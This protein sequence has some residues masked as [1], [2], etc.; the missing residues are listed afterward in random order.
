MPKDEIKFED[1]LQNVPPGNLSFVHDMHDFMLQN[2]CTYKIAEA[3]SGH[4]L[5]Y[6]VPKTKKVLANYVFRKNGMLIRIYGDNISKYTDI[7]GNLPESMAKSIEGAPP[8]TRL[9]DPTK[10]NSRCP[11]GY[12]FEFNGKT[13]QSCRYNSFMFDIEEANHAAIRSFL[14]RELGERA[15]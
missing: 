7:L 2:K 8:C 1:F 4:V 6:L 3:K 10:C 14:E 11:L 5:S 9:I 15:A 12:V 13:M